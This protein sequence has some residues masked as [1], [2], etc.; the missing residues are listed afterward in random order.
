MNQSKQN[1][2]KGKNKYMKCDKCIKKE[3]EKCEDRGLPID[4]ILIKRFK[5]NAEFSDCMHENCPGCKNGTCGGAH[6]M[7]C[8]CKRCS[9]RMTC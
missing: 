3:I 5:S 7:S 9:P 6:M 8:P 2:L 1:K 4:D